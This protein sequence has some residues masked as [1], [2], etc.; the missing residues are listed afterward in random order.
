MPPPFASPFALQR[1]PVA[2]LSVLT[3]ALAAATAVL[4]QGS[5]PP[6]PGQGQAAAQKAPQVA[7]R[8]TQS[9]APFAPR[10]ASLK[11]DRV[12][13]RRG[14]GPDHGID[15]VYRRAGLP[16]EVIA[17]SEIWRR[18]RDAEGGSGWV[19]GSLLSSRRTALV[20]PWEI[21]ASVAPPQVPLKSDDRESAPDVAQ[22]EAGVIVSVRTCDGRWCFVGIGDLRG[23]IEQRRLWGVYKGEMIR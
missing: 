4:A 14:P 10:F 23:Y 17:E 2:V 8:A 21:K 16:V 18:V 20:E 11:S 6:A 5:L 19:L 7:P 13:V 12:N 22:L 9:A 15:W 3:V 1:L